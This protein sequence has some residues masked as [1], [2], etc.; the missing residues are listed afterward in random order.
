MSRTV[1]CPS[2]HEWDLEPV[3]SAAVLD[4]DEAAVVLITD[5]QPDYQP[6]TTHPTTDPTTDPRPPSRT[7]RR[8]DRPDDLRAGPTT[9][10]PDP[11]T[12]EPD[13]TTSEPDPQPPT[14]PDH[15]RAGP[16]PRPPSRTRHNNVAG[17]SRTLPGPTP[18]APART[19][20]SHR[21]GP[22]VRRAHTRPPSRRSPRL[23]IRLHPASPRPPPTRPNHRIDGQCGRFRRALLEHD[24]RHGLRPGWRTPPDGGG[25]LRSIRRL[26]GSS[27]DHG[28]VTG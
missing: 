4:N 27:L 26:S 10:E 16:E 8:S 1:T 6:P 19:D 28:E 20:R 23:Q 25:Q 17:P 22:T 11:T 9:S 3:D 15:L 13:P 5:D 2:G 24:Y 18:G 14:G 7:R 12:S 21:P